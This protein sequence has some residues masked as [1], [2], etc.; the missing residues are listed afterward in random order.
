MDTIR[1]ALWGA[2][3][4]LGGTGTRARVRGFEVGGKT[5]TAQVVA[6]DVDP[7]RADLQDHAW[8]VGFAPYGDPEI[9]VS[10]F[11]ENG[12]GGGAAAAPVSQAIMQVYFDKKGGLLTQG[13]VNDIAGLDTEISIAR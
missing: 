6:K 7:S 12:G 4:D 11:V 3:N 5:G 8:F 2:V 10:V 1:E 9:V 13:D